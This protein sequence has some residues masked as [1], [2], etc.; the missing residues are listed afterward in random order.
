MIYFTNDDKGLTTSKTSFKAFDKATEISI[1]ECEEILGYEIEKE[2]DHRPNGEVIEGHFHLVRTDLDK[3]VGRVGVGND[4]T[5]QQPVTL[6]R[7]IKETILP[8]YPNLAIESCGTLE[9]GATAF[10][11]LRGK[12]FYIEGDPS[13]VSQRITIFDP[14]TMGAIKIVAHLVR[15]RNNVAIGGGAVQKEGKWKAVRDSAKAVHTAS[16]AERV[17]ASAKG[18]A[19]AL[20]TIEKLG[21]MTNALASVNLTPEIVNTIF[22]KCFPVYGVATR[23]SSRNANIRADVM[24]RLT[25]GGWAKKTAWSLLVAYS[26]YLSNQSRKGMDSLHIEWDSMNGNRNSKKVDFTNTLLEMV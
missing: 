22:D 3:V 5:I 25:N 19:V 4:F 8:T 24:S 26:E 15:E 1:E 21:G 13:P 6:A 11:S 20:Q 18:F 16:V 2:Y 7:L 10:I 23:V 17:E 14:M 9:G 12:S